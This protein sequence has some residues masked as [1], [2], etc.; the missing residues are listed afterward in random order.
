MDTEA[1][2]SQA[3]QIL[4]PF[5]GVV[6]KKES[7]RLDA[8]IEVK[9]LKNAVKALEDAHWGYLMTISGLDH[10]ANEE[11]VEGVLEAAYFFANINAV[12]GLRVVVPYSNP[13][14]PS[15]CDLIPSATIYERELMEL[16]GVDF[17]DTPVRDRLVLPDDWPEGVY[18]LRKS[19]K[20]FETQAV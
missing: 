19:F 5:A 16:F 11:Q 18:P 15:I 7:N 12:V 4:S 10:P 14:I 3:E 9:N 1:L 20:G 2:L 17:K 6:L 8:V 13:V